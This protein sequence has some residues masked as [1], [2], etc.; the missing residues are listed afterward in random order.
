[1]A[2]EVN[3]LMD[4]VKIGASAVK[5]G[6]D[7]VKLGVKLGSSVEKTG[8]LA[9]D[10]SD[11]STT[12]SGRTSDYGGDLAKS[13]GFDLNGG[14]SDSYSTNER[15]RE[16][17][18]DLNGANDEQLDAIMENFKDSKWSDMS[19]EEQ[20][21]S[22]TD[23]A[24]FVTADIGLK[25][26]P[27]IVF[28]DDM[29][30]GSYGGYNPNSN[31]IEINTNMLYDNVE[32]AD[33][34]AHEMWHAYQEQAAKDPNDPR[35]AEYQEAFDNYITPDIDFEAYQEQMIEAEARDYAQA[36]KDRLSR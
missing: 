4:M 12:D 33:T 16:V 1:M 30:D 29:P 23:L 15:D 2:K 14:A 17:G 3:F 34:I 35:A 20:K 26:P 19:L 6:A 18:K 31:V 36:F 10:K 32:A 7:A 13:K 9:S 8:D 28:R 21:K 24:D 27:E 11:R 22:I 25:N 5:L